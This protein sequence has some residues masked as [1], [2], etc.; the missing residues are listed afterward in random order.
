MIVILGLSEKNGRANKLRIL[1]FSDC[2][3]LMTNQIKPNTAH[4]TQLGF[5][6]WY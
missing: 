1:D 5:M 3:M 2:G 6:G 4:V